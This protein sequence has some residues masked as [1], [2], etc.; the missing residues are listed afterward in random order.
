[1]YYPYGRY[2][3]YPIRSLQQFPP[4]PPCNGG[5][6]YTV[7]PGDTMFRIA[8]QYGLSLQSVINANPQVTNPNILFPGQQLCI[9]AIVTPPP[10][11]PFC[12]NGT[13][14]TV[15]RGDTIFSI[16]RRYGVTVQQMI[17][18]NPQIADPNLIEVGQR[19]CI[20]IP[21]EPPTKGIC[22]V[23]L[24]P[25]RPGVLGG[26][27]FVNI[28]TPTVWIVAFGLPAP[29]EID[30]KYNTYRAW[31]HNKDKDQY[32]IVELKA[33]GEPGI[34]VGYRKMEGTLE[35]YTEMIVTVET[36]SNPTKPSGPILLRG[37]ITP[38]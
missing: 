3:P 10:P 5:T 20:P 15:Q 38:C 6:I 30:S 21:V 23:D 24:K 19:V 28:T 36:I 18:A 1:M 14:Y 32:R 7:R 22:M 12:A 2:Y 37:I 33:S 27:A 11:E 35:G 13:I 8:N 4:P 9:P 26:T 34:E 17:R 25:L 31:L 16:A 29:A